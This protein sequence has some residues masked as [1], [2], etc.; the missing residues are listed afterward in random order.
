MSKRD[1]LLKIFLPLI[2]LLAGIMITLVMIKMRQ[3]PHPEERA[4][5]GP[6]VDVI[7]VSTEPHQ[8]V[9]QGTGTVQSRYQSEVTP[10]VSGVI[11]SIASNMVAGGFFRKGETLFTIESLDYQL[12]LERAQ[13]SLAQA[14]LELIRIKSQADIAREEWTRL[15]MKDVSE[16]NPLVLYEPQLKTAQAAL[17]SAR[18][19][20]R[21]AELDLERTRVTAPFNCYVRHE[22]VDLGQY[23]RAGNAVATLVGT[24]EVEILVPLPLEE[25]AWLDVPRSGS[26]V[27]GSLANV[28]LDVAGQQLSWQGKIVRALG[29]VDPRNRMASIVVSVDDPFGQHQG[30]ELSPGMFV[31]VELQGH[32]L[33]DVVVLPRGA[34]R[35][36]DTVWVVGDGNRLEI[37]T[38]NIVRRERRVVMVRDGLADGEHIVLSG[39]SGA[40]NGL[41]V[42]PQTQETGP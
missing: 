4:F 41:L 13:S 10:Q 7:T 36:Q 19:A 32:N 2:I 23:L 20:V 37:R 6:L 25:L 21:Q 9:V 35:D 15:E 38:V 12:A 33:G 17:L 34:L 30:L 28:Q 29:D 26:E 18:A 11:D 22:Q 42:R 3:L 8:V 39:L 24:D 5:V 16:P 14:E 1:L 40:A 27:P 31:E